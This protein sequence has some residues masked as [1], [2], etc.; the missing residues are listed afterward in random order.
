MA[1]A[2][3]LGGYYRVPPDLRDLNYGKYLD[4]GESKFDDSNEYNSDNTKDWMYRNE[5]YASKT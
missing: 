4:T 2:D 1:Q 3:D 5:R